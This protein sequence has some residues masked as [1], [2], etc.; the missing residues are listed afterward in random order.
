MLENKDYFGHD[1]SRF[2]HE[3]GLL[4]RRLEREISCLERQLERLF[5]LDGHID[6]RTQ[7]TY[8]EMISSRKDMLSELGF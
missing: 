2:K 5:M 3:S 1:E 8:S 4:I 7:D 6:K